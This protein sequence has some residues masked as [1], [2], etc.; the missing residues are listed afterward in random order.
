MIFTGIEFNALFTMGVIFMIL[1]AANKKKWKK[2]SLPKKQK[3]AWALT[4]FAML[5]LGAL[6]LYARLVAA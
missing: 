6:A 3:I 4:F 1:G 5:L 2:G